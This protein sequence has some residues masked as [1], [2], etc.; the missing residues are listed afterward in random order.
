MAKPTP[1][2]PATSLPSHNHPPRLNLAY[3]SSSL[4][5]R[6]ANIQATRPSSTV[7]AVLAAVAASSSTVDGRPLNT[8]SEPLDF[9]C[10]IL[11]SDNSDC[12]SSSKTRSNVADVDPKLYHLSPTPTRNKRRPSGLPDKY[13]PGQDGRWRRETSWSLYGSTHCECEDLTAPPTAAPEVDDQVDPSQI[14]NSEQTTSQPTTSTDMTANLPPGWEGVGSGRD[15]PIYIVVLSILLAILIFGTIFGCVGWRRKRRE[16]A[17]MDQEKR[18][19]KQKEGYDS[20]TEPEEVKQARTQ[21]K[22]W[23]KASAKWRS[24]IRMSARRRRRRPTQVVQDPEPRMSTDTLVSRSSEAPSTIPPHTVGSDAPAQVD[25]APRPSTSH[26]GDSPHNPPPTR[27]SIDASRPT[28][29]PQYPED[30]IPST[31]YRQHPAVDRP[32]LLDA[33]RASVEEGSLEAHNPPPTGD[34]DIPYTAPASGHVATDDKT[35]LAR[36]AEYASAP[37]VDDGISHGISHVDSHGV[38]GP[39]VP[40]IEELEQGVLELLN[41]EEAQPSYSESRAHWDRSVLSNSVFSSSGLSS[42]PAPAPIYSRTPSPHPDSRLP[43]PPAFPPPPTKA[44]LFYEY[45][46]SFEAD[47]EGTEPEPNPSAPP[48]EYVSGPSAPPEDVFEPPD[49]SAVACAPPLIDE[50]EETQLGLSVAPTSSNPHPWPA[51][52]APSFE[53]DRRHQDQTAE[54]R[55]HP[56]NQPLNGSRPSTSSGADGTARASALLARDRASSPPGYLP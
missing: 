33:R 38:A 18:M 37:P 30:S 34:G 41:D 17:R 40:G 4:S 6:H 27:A 32:S 12:A 11:A 20:D 5:P 50:E 26:D 13:A 39:S 29:P 43:H 45:P 15:V 24:G 48:F 16:F 31:S 36:L 2:T 44:Q 22:M 52:T 3:S 25:N 54:P 8:D 21:Q 51:M 23:A 1:S 47:V 28:H 46:S 42:L 14:T 9:L 49:M 56:Q 55:P 35:V 10:P 53:E 19:R 7:L